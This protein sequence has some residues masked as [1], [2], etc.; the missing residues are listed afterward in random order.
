M[1]TFYSILIVLEVFLALAG[2]WC[3]LNEKKLIVF[4]ERLARKIKTAVRLKAKRRAAE[5]RR[6]INARVA[7]SP[8]VPQRRTAERHE[9]A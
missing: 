9:A 7:Y 3:I 4:E 8:E 2:A 6:R 1:H 5:K